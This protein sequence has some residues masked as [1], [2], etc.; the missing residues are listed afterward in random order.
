MGV[1]T[2]GDAG[3]PLR[4][5]PAPRTLSQT[6]GERTGSYKT[7][8]RPHGNHMQPTQNLLQ[9]LRK[10]HVNYM[11][12]TQNF[13]QTMRTSCKLYANLMQTL[14]KPHAKGA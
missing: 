2:Q 7:T 12:T 11:R 3:S 8:C 14:W 4:G 13:L 1:M 5:C 6:A 10:P 9:T